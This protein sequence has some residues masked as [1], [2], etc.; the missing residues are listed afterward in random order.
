MSYQKE[1]VFFYECLEKNEVLRRLNGKTN[2]VLVDTIGETGGNKY[3]IKGAKTIPYDELIDRRRE[4]MKYDEIILYSHNRSCMLSKKRA[5]GL[6]L[7]SYFTNVKI[8][9]GG[10]EEWMKNGLPVEEYL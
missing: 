4:L 5:V 2:F 10:I 6:L 3:R 7:F 1:F 8:Y 9:E